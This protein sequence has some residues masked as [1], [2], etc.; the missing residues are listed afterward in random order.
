MPDTLAELLAKCAAGDE[1]AVET[2]VRR[3][4]PWALD[5]AAAILEDRSMA[6]DVV[7]EAFVAALQKLPALREPEAF[8]GWFRQVI[9]THV[10]RFNRRKKE[11]VLDEPEDVA[12]T[13]PDPRENLHS[14]RVAA[15]VR[16]ALASLP[17]TNR[18]PAQLFYL[19]EMKQTDIAR[20]LDVP[21]GTV[22]RRLHDARRTLRLLLMG[23]LEEPDRP[24]R[25]NAPAN[26]PTAHT[27]KEK[28]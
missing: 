24:G 3:F 4:Q 12:S 18:H 17:A 21:L 9:R 27:R 11:G 23:V 25:G 13:D 26:P 20:Q 19:D 2:L 6:H 14:R 5:F 22:K 7:Q 15:K 10:S 16:D 8:P 28:S 1:T